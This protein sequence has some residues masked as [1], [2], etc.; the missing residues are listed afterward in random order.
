MEL[1]ADG[2]YNPIQAPV[3]GGGV[4]DR[5]AYTVGRKNGS[6]AEVNQDYAALM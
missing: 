1:A 3:F 6:P 4:P 5:G 2:S